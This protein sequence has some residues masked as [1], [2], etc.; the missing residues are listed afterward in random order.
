[1]GKKISSKTVK[2][3]SSLGF[4]LIELLLA[5]AILAIL[6][7]L[8]APSFERLLATNRMAGSANELLGAMQLGRTEALK[9]R[10]PVS[11]CPST[12]GESCGGDWVD[13]WIVTVDGSAVG[14]G[15]VTIVDSDE[16]VLR[17]WDG[18]RGDLQFDEPGDLPAFVRFLPDGRVDGAG[19]TFPFTF[20]VQ[21]PSCRLNVGRA[22]E[23]VA[24]GRSSVREV[25]C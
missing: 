19:G 6:L 11:L 3:D 7:A 8:A 16:D 22:V 15:S 4:T 21:L 13:G 10:G 2:R 9:R 20:Q 25:T 17:V 24:T 14:N 5:I 18:L 12:D 23:V 1:M